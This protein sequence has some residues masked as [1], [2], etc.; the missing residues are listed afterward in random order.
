MVVRL[1]EIIAATVAATLLTIRILRIPAA[2]PH[3]EMRA[4]RE[5]ERLAHPPES[6]GITQPQMRQYQA[7]EQ[8]PVTYPRLKWL[9]IGIVFLVFGLWLFIRFATIVIDVIL[10]VAVAVILATALRPAVDRIS[11]YRLPVIQMMIARPLAILMIY[12]VLS[13]ILVGIGFLVVPQLIAELQQLIANIPDYSEAIAAA[14]AGMERYPFLPNVERLQEQL[15]DQLATGITQAIDVLLF[16]VR[17]VFSLLSFL[18][19]LVIAFFLLMEAQPLYEHLLALAPPSRRSQICAMTDEMGQKVEGW[20]KGEFLL[21]A[22]VGVI[23]ALGMWALGMPFPLILGLLAGFFELIPL[24]GAYLGA[25]PAVIVALF[26]PPL[27]LLAV[28]LFFI[29]LQQ[30]ENN[31][32]AP[33]IMGREVE[34]PPLLTIVALLTGA[35]LYGILGALLSLPIA[36]VLQV[37]WLRL[38]VPAIRG[39]YGESD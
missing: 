8:P 36:A 28:V 22:F 6:T 33:S 5:R 2:K 26:Q 13:A 11:S 20:L 27:T 7:T 12:L 39:K 16:L 1:L 32:L 17:L 35:S 24:V 15:I 9:T 18:V 34:I 30:F 37:L 19:V 4:H 23:T 10:L 21:S 31:I 25:A 29:A 38:V 14:L 3:H